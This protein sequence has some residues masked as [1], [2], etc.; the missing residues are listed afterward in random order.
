MRGWL[1]LL[2]IACVAC[3]GACRS[4]LQL[5]TLTQ[6]SGSEVERDE[7]TEV[8]R[9]Q[10][11][12]LSDSF[13]MGDGL[14]T[15]PDSRAQL[16]L[17]PS[18]S[19]EI[20]PRT[21][22][23]FLPRAPEAHSTSVALEQGAVE[24]SA[25]QMDLEIHTPRAVAR[26]A[27]G[28]KL[29]LSAGAGRERFDLMVG[30]VQVV[31][32]GATRTL[33]PNRTLEL[34]EP[35]APPTLSALA[36]EPRVEQ[37]DAGTEQAPQVRPKPSPSDADL[38][39]TKLERATVH[40][41]SLPL[42]VYLP[43]PS[44][45]EPKI[46][47]DGKPLAG[48]GLARLAAGQHRV[49]ML[50]GS[51]KVRDTLLSVRRDA[52]KLELPERAQQVRVEADGRHYTVRYQNLLP[53]V[54]FVWPDAPKGDLFTLIVRKSGHE[55]SYQVSE[56]QL[57]LE[58]DA[59]SEGEYTFWFLDGRGDMSKTGTL[60]L[61]FD[62]TARSAYLSSPAEGSA[63]TGDRVVIAGATLMRSEVSVD[64]RALQLDDKGRFRLEATVERGQ[65]AVAVRIAH[66]A[67]GV[68]YYLRRLR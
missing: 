24:L 34:A 1:A 15:G 20:G 39:L 18:G 59:L 53:T 19:A 23:R 61:A 62:N 12:R 57:A 4:E 64:G 32:A 65:R 50:C 35:A 13:F 38:V 45:L 31:H 5:A 52:A 22:L 7:A 21:V 63:P 29:K 9:W 28:G 58:A 14:R 67:S 11:A 66:P 27:R 8:G 43:L 37:T 16:G 41:A 6:L 10:A 55:A 42:D 25:E 2:C 49:R 56:P 47:L 3:E 51:R 44:C 68:H 36:P 33:E 48:S 40:A 46:V 60:R 30:R 17:L 26:V 54:S